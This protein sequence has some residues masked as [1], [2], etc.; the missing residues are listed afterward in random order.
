MITIPLCA[1][2]GHYLRNDRACLPF[3]PSPRIQGFQ[4]AAWLPLNLFL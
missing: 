3:T 1:R 4:K 2:K